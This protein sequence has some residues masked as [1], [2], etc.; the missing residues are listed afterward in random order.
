MRAKTCPDI[1]ARRYTEG[2]GD[3]SDS[4]SGIDI[5]PVAP[6]FD[7]T[8]SSPAAVS[9]FPSSITGE[10]TGPDFGM[11]LMIV[12]VEMVAIRIAATMRPIFFTDI[13]AMVGTPF[14]AS[15]LNSLILGTP[16]VG[17]MREYNCG[18]GWIAYHV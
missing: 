1:F 10:V 4:E 8:F 17:K 9:S 15:D 3:A 18:F 11:R 12:M 14:A 16:P 2:G 5:S 6:L 7:I 13:T